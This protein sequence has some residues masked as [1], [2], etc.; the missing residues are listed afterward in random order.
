MARTRTA[1]RRYAEAVF[2][3]ADRDNA[4]DRWLEDLRTA[5]ELVDRPDVGRIVNSPM[6]PLA[7][8][9]ALLEQTLG[10]RISPKA[11][12]LVGLLAG[13]GN[14]EMLG[15]I[16]TEYQRLLNQRR[17]VVTAV[18][19]SAMPMTSEEDKAV[20]AKVAGMTGTTVDMEMRVD[21]ELI[22]GM[23][24][25]IGDRLIDGSVRGRLERL[26]EQLLA[27]TRQAG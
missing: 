21:P 19:T 2:Q 23:T 24:V 17:N 20:R 9:Q 13:R 14:L 16:A 18:V 12:N 26:R 27:G 7:D 4:L 25:R 10:S 3:L 6:V 11:L 1:A 22:G 8:R 15:P 5:A